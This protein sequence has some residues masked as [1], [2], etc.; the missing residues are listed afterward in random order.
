MLKQLIENGEKIYG[1]LC[2]AKK[3][4]KLEQKTWVATCLMYIEEYLEDSSV[5]R[6]VLEYELFDQ[7]LTKENAIIILA[8]L[9][10]DLSIQELKQKY[11]Q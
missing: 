8:A 1:D 3:G 9:K 7:S 2:Q 10:S 4:D 11:G 6:V 5:G